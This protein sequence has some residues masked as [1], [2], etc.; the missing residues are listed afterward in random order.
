VPVDGSRWHLERADGTLIAGDVELATSMWAR[1][2]GLMGRRA[3]PEGHALYIRPCN[4][5]HMFFMRFPI[6][7]VFVDADGRVL[8]I[9]AG[10]K[11]W[12]VTRIVRRSKA[13]VELPAGALAAAGVTVGDVVKL[14]G[15]TGISG[16]ATP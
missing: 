1:F 12:R 11:P 16:L 4:S 9:Y 2:M 3:L 5:I 10:L 6:D 13:V 8:R 14:V 7:A 15:A